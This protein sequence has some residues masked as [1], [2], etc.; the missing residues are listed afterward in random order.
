[1]KICDQCGCVVKKAE[2]VARIQGGMMCLKCLRVVADSMSSPNDR[3]VRPGALAHRAG[4]LKPLPFDE[5]V[6]LFNRFRKA[7]K[8]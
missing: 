4:P 7:G 3:M 6:E 1:M 2:M 5:G 8:I